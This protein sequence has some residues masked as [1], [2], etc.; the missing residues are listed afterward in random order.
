MSMS[1]ATETCPEP[2][3]GKESLSGNPARESQPRHAAAILTVIVLA[4]FA[5]RAYELGDRSLWFDE[6]F[7]WRII[8][9]P[10]HKMIQRVGW[11]NHPPLHFILL[12]GW[13]AIFGASAFA[14]R[15][16]SVLFGCLT[17]LGTYLFCVE[18]FGS[19]ALTVRSNCDRGAR[20][21]GIG[22][23]AAAFVALSAFQIRYSQESRMYSLAAALAVFSSWALFRALRTPS[24]IGPW[25]LYGLLGLLLAYSHYYG[26]FSLAAQAVFIAVVLLGR[27]HWGWPRLVRDPT[28]WHVLLAVAIAT[29]GWLPWLS[30]FRQQIQRQYSESGATIVDLRSVAR[31][32]YDLFA[33]RDYSFDNPSQEVQLLAAGFCILLLVL[34]GYKARAADWYVLGSAVTPL[35]CAVIVSAPMFL[36]YFIM[37]H[38]FLLVGLAVLV[39][40]VSFRLERA[41]MTATI[42]LVLAALYIDFWDDLDAAHRPGTRS[43]GAFLQEHRRPAEPVII[44]LPLFYF[45]LM[46]YAANPTGYFLYSDGHPMPHT[47]GTA[48]MTAE[49]L[50]VDEQLRTQRSPRV[51]VVD[52]EASYFGS[53]SVPVPSQWVEKSRHSFANVGS[54]GTAIV[55]E[56]QTAASQDGDANPGKP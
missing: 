53:R 43:A 34:L 6:A 46:H 23:L 21:Q 40:R 22:L 15:S 20:G 4:G 1:P 39:W 9:F 29:V 38:V 8:Q 26:L 10:L 52:L 24:R 18:A 13:A 33:V 14:M 55:V 28:L 17:I 36:R 32:C 56:Y 16:L 51:W 7:S 37:A 41:I 49:D 5:I 45:S 47:W 30:I 31:L 25:L 2:L 19:N 50:M 42:L 54:I 12:Q 11:D 35:L 44:C 3:G 48:A 27:S